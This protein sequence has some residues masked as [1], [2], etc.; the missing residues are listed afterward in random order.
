M[1]DELLTVDDL[2]VDGR[3]V[4]LRADLDVP[5]RQDDAAGVK[6]VAD[7][8]RIRAALPSIEELSRLGA[9]LVLIS[10]LGRPRGREV[11]LSMRPV[12]EHLARLTG[13]AVRLAP[14]VVG[15]EVR[16]LTQAL[17]PGEMLMLENARFEAGETRND[18]A[19]SSELAELGDLYVDDA[20]ADA[21][22]ALASNEGVARRL[23]A[24]AGRLMEREVRALRTITDDPERPL[25]AV[26]GGVTVAEQIALLRRLLQLVDVLC[27]GGQM[28]L[29]FLVASGHSPPDTR[30]PPEDVELARLAL[31]E[32]T[33]SGCT[34]ELPRD[35]MLAPRPEQAISVRPGALDPAEGYEG[36]DVGRATVHRFSAEIAAAATVYW[37]G[38]MGNLED[39]LAAGTRA[40]ARAVASSA[41]RTV[42]AGE[43]AV[44]VLKSLRLAGYVTHVSSG[45]G[46]TRAF[47]QGR[48]LPAVKVLLR[49]RPKR[50]AEPG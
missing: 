16:E 15:R 43:E 17:A 46:A 39:P 23:R 5:L 4:L 40:L 42:V 10:D 48:E 34:V 26:L 25:V 29:P 30:C 36:L 8:S 50:G 38:P 44:Q 27:I 11:A 2:N 3:R 21:H 9:R 47:L 35:L 6:R 14:A 45:N 12:A 1:P 31:T 18:P 20:F 32:A 13:A 24:A 7:D 37:D 33:A 19:L 28:C 22:R 49:D 41:A